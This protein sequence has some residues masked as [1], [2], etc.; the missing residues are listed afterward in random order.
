MNKVDLKE[1]IE[2]KD[3][4]FLKKVKYAGLNDLEYWDSQN[5][6]VGNPL[7]LNIYQ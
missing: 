4:L 5:L 6:M 3:E 1:L 2:S 7:N